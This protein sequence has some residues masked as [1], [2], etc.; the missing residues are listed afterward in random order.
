MIAVCINKL[1]LHKR[2]TFT[3]HRKQS[4][5]FCLPSL[6]NWSWKLG[7]FLNQ[8]D[9]KWQPIA[10]DQGQLYFPILQTICLFILS[11]FEYS[12]LILSLLW[13]V[14]IAWFRFHHTSSKSAL[15]QCVR[16]FLVLTAFT[17]TSC[18][19]FLGSPVISFE[20]RLLLLLMAFYR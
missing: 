15:K 3:D 13:L 18:F 10:T 19:V 20:R 8:C 16:V 7:H 1:W 12:Y 2:A 14:L 5:R 4:L 9:S 11:Y 6:W 17:C